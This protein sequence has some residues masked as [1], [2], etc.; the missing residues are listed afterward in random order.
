MAVE[1]RRA[2]RIDLPV[3]AHLPPDYIASDRLRLEAYRRLSTVTT[4][5]EVDDIRDESG[6]IIGVAKIARDITEKKEYQRALIAATEAAAAAAVTSPAPA[7]FRPVADPCRIN[8]IKPL[9]PLLVSRPY[10]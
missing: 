5:T 2:L 7:S 6:A 4:H 1:G 8:P 9:I 3:D 10:G